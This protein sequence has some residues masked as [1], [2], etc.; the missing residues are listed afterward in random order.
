M[1]YKKNDSQ[2]LERYSSAITLSDMEVFI[3][4]ELLYAL[5]LA[6]IMS[7]RLWKWKNDPWFNSIH[8][9]NPSKRMQ[10]LKQYIMDHFSFNL[11]LDTWGLTDKD[12]ELSRFNAF[13]NQTILSESNALFGYEGDKYYF[14]IDI[15]KHFGLDKYNSDIIPYWK[16]ETLEAMEAFKFKDG[17]PAGA[18][19]CVSLAALYASSSFAIAD[20]PLQSIYLFATPLH[21]Q[22]F[23]DIGDGIITNNRRIV[24]KNMWYNGTELS[25]KAR[26]ALENEKVTIVANNTGY[27]HTMYKTATINQDSYKHFRNKVKNYLKTEITF[28]ILANFLRQ[29]SQLQ[30]CFQIAHSCCGKPRYLPAERAYQYEHSSKYRVGDE[31]QDNLLHEIEEDE[32]YTSPI[33]H[34]MVLRELELFFREN[35]VIIDSA[36]TVELL[37]KSLHHE[38][39][40]VEEVVKDLIAFCKINPRLPDTE[41]EWVQSEP[42]NLDDVKNAQDALE[43]IS[44]Y[45]TKN[46]SADLAFSAYRDM[47]RSPWKPFL[48]A[49]LERNPV[50]LHALRDA[51][52]QTM[53]TKI[54]SLENDSIYDESTRLAQPDE[55]WNFGRG[56]GLEKALCF[57]N[58]LGKYFPQERYTLDYS[59][60]KVNVKVNNNDFTFT[61]NKMLTPPTEEDFSF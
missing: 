9:M 44:E 12:T 49:A 23:L 24:T 26:R 27:I 22:N 45:R 36:S 20:I 55:V 29:N 32:Y 14:D 2:S 5:M 59:G 53:F 28:E 33:P 54:S 6:N 47:S 40:N 7:P 46:I 25:A 42:V 61:T 35:K 37:R 38:C 21:S 19:E 11:D 50:I 41:K 10:R 60:K 51:D 16:T 34:R 3:F 58:V 30:C 48:K 39:I 56:D 31:T 1:F 52:L 13:I 15:R 43:R 17:Y 8:K 18:G 4:P 57:I